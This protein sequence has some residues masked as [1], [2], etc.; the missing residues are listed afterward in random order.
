L[1]DASIGNQNGAPGNLQPRRAPSFWRRT[2][3]ALD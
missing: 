3:L 2:S 1:T